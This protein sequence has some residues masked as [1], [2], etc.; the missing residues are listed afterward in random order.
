MKVENLGILHE[1]PA[2][3]NSEFKQLLLVQTSEGVEVLY[4]RSKSVKNWVLFQDEKTEF[5]NNHPD[6]TG[7]GFEATL[8]TFYPPILD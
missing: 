6:T 4:S 5:T 2:V 1:L 7:R 8:I 3:P